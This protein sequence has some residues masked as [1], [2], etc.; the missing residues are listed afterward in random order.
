MRAAIRNELSGRQ[1]ELTDAEQ[2]IAATLETVSRDIFRVH[3]GQQALFAILDCGYIRENLS[4][5]RSSLTWVPEPPRDAVDQS[6]ARARGRYN[7]FVKSAGQTRY[8]TAPP[9]AAD[10]RMKSFA[11]LRD[12]SAWRADFDFNACQ[13][14]L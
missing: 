12:F 4:Y 14:I 2:R 6:V 10:L 9:A 5:L 3:R 13:T 11:R 7:R 1:G 8:G